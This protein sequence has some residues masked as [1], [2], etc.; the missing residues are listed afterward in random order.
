M[1]F[2]MD[3]LRVLTLIIKSQLFKQKAYLYLAFL[4]GVNYL[5]Y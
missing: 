2:Q 1:I 3:R 5:E 4:D